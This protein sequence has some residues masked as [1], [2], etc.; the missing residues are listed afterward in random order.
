M[1]AKDWYKT[2]KVSRKTCFRDFLLVGI[3]RN[4]RWKSVGLHNC[5]SLLI[6]Y[7][8]FSMGKCKQEKTELLTLCLSV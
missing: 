3:A 5:I 1:L 8:Y 2:K 7:H 4:S 6:W